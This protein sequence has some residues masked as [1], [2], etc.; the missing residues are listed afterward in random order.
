MSS[1]T[2]SIDS[3]NIVPIKRHGQL[4]PFFAVHGEGNVFFYAHLARHLEK[5]RPMY[6]LEACGL[7]GGPLPFSKL[8]D[9]AA[10]YVRQVRNIQRSG[11]YCIGG[12]CLGAVIA[13]EM[14]RQLL[15]AGHGVPLLVM[16]DTGPADIPVEDEHDHLI[17]KD[18]P[19]TWKD[20]RDH[21]K[22]I[23][24]NYQPGNYS[25]RLVLIQSSRLQAQGM[26]RPVID[27]I[28]DQYCE[29]PERYGVD[30]SDGAMFREPCVK[31]VAAILN[32]NL[33]LLDDPS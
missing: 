23:V 17:P 2:R 31:Q 19:E 8:I 3:P 32:R 14:A 4:V 21:Y 22:T 13:F 25:G 10:E 33:S 11:P 5:D 1:V 15:D 12:Y 28:L 7:D 29:S 6:A 9:Y 26:H 18:I 27:R 24:R 16:F 20:V 30:H